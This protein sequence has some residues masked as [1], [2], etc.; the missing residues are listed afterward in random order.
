M[1]KK[2]SLRRFLKDQPTQPSTPVSKN[3]EE[4]IRPSLQ[5]LMIVAN[6]VYANHYPE[7]AQEAVNITLYHLGVGLTPE[8]YP[9][10]V[11]QLNLLK[12]KLVQDIPGLGIGF[13]YPRVTMY[14]NL[15]NQLPL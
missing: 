9:V 13:S 5:V 2:I 10:V 12:E 7:D 14:S 4:Q 11:G 6:D 1:V 8:T 3:L 15:L